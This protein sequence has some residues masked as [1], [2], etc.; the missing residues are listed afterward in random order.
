MWFILWYRRGGRLEELVHPGPERN[1]RR[2]LE[3]QDTQRLHLQIP[4]YV[5][6]HARYSKVLSL[7]A[8]IRINIQ[9]TWRLRLQVAYDVCIAHWYSLYAYMTIF[10]SFCDHNTLSLSFYKL[11]LEQTCLGQIWISIIIWH[12]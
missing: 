12:K 9:D 3:L 4:V 7:D 8:V 5:S 6:R 11:T 1:V 10:H 2:R